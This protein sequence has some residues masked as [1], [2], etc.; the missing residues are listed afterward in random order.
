M[1]FTVDDGPYRR[2]DDPENAEF[3]RALAQGRTPRELSDGNN[4]NVVV[5]LVDKR[6]EDYVE[7]FQSFSGAGASLGT[8]SSS[9]DGSGV[10]DPASLHEPA[11]AADGAATTSIAVRL[12]NGKRKIVKVALTST[13]TD[14]AAHLR[15]DADGSPFRLVSGF[16]PKPIQDAL[17]TIDAA[18]LKGAQVSMQKV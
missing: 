14:L 4:G 12:P 15:D 17:A 6:T 18:G 13:V 1:G 16:P 3:L 5:G 11:A 7:T 9:V 8:T 10:F 2:L